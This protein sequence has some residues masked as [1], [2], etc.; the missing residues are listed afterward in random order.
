MSEKRTKSG[1]AVRS[2]IALFLVLMGIVGY[3]L[4]W[5]LVLSLQ[6]IDRLSGWAYA[7]E[8]EFYG[9]VIAINNEGPEPFRSALR[10]YTAHL[11]F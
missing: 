8:R 2:T 9:P 10:W 6:K 5:G 7:V 3:P 11:P 1:V 4:S